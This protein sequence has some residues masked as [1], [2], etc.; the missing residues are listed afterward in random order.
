MKIVE[1]LRTKRPVV[2]FEFFPPRNDEGSKNLVEVLGALK[3]LSP[4]FVSMTY[5]AGGST[6]QK[7]IALVSDIKHKIGLETMAHLTCVGHSLIE[8][9]VILKELY[10]AGI[11]N[12]LALRGDPPRGESRFVPAPDGFR[13]A[14]DLVAFIKAH[15]SFCIGVA[16]YPEKHPEA[17]SLEEDMAHLKGKVGKGGEFVI[18]QLF[19]DNRDYFHFVRRLQEQG[20]S[21]P[22]IPGIMPIT[23][24]EQIK[25]FTTVCGAK[26][27]PSLLKKLEKVQ[28]NKDAVVQ[29]GI[30]YAVDQCRELLKKGAPGIHFY[31]LNKSKSTKEIFLRL[32]KERLVK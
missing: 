5:G 29:E 2:S 16:G 10:S 12:V 23:D 7:T 27:P 15:F 14:A 17:P 11:E 24:V 6:R 25:R 1:L 19:F 26:I 18:T 32:K 21:V 28:T 30:A 3:D 22:V 31:T 13:Y 8:L 9:H 20:V 4:S